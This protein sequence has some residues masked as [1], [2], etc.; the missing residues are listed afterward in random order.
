MDIV[1]KFA[2]VAKG[3]PQE[4]GFTYELSAVTDG[5]VENEKFFEATPWGILQ[6]GTVNARAAAELN[7]GDQVY[8][9]ISKTNP[10]DK[11]E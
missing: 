5:S 1:C 7:V 3:E 10:F 6:F 11:S 4:N 8:V 9:T 2:V